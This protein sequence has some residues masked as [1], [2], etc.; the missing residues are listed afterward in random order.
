M[1]MMMMIVVAAAVGLDAS[2]PLMI[3]VGIN[4]G[5]RCSGGGGGFSG[6]GRLVTAIKNGRPQGR[7]RLQPLLNLA[8]MDAVFPGGRP[9]IPLAV[10][11]VAVR[12]QHLNLEL[13][14]KN[15]TRSHL[16]GGLGGG[17]GF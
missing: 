14:R 2:P 3:I 13:G 6:S 15:P 9:L 4:P 8:T 12:V 5:A 10:A 11:V 17:D 7:L 1:Q 16:V